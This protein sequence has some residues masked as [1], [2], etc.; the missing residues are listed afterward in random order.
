[1]RRPWLVLLVLIV[2]SSSCDNSQPSLVL[3]VK[4][5]RGDEVCVRPVDP[6]FDEYA[7]CY[8]LDS[9]RP[10]AEGDCIRA[11]VPSAEVEEQKGDPLTEVSASDC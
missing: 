6:A 9:T 4:E 10:V 1:M 2:M 8:R 11:R 3:Q 5:V 7:G